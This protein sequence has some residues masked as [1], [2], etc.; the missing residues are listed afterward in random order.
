MQIHDRNENKS[1][2]YLAIGSWTLFLS[3]S[4]Q[5]QPIVEILGLALLVTYGKSWLYCWHVFLI[6]YEYGR[7]YL[8]WK[9]YFCL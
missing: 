5:F 1:Y 3:L 8:T 4:Y 6:L 2:P 7:L 9:Q